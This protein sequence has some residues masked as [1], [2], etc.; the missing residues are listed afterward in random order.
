MLTSAEYLLKKSIIW[1]K[2]SGAEFKYLGDYIQREV[3][4]YIIYWTLRGLFMR[5]DVHIALI[6]TNIIYRTLDIN[7][8]RIYFTKETLRV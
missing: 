8:I 3:L 1:K 2:I 5:I 6:L 7:K 4:A